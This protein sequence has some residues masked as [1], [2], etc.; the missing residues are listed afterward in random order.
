MKKFFLTLLFIPF[1]L[2][3]CG[4]DNPG[5]GDTPVEHSIDVPISEVSIIEGHEFQ[6]PIEVLKPT[7]VVCRSNNEEIA[8]VTHNGLVTGVKEG[9]TTINISGGQDHFIVFVTVLEETSKASLQITMPKYNF[10]LKAGDKYNLPIT[11]K[12]GS[13]VIKDPALSYEFEKEGIVSISELTVTALLAGTTKCVVTAL[14]NELEVSELF[15][16]TVY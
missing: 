7:I 14:Y 10:T 4:S 5:G 15:T 12:Y 13:S 2:G 3:G 1:L 9:E 8:T 6:I 11:V 16:L